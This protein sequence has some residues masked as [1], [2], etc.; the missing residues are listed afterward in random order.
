M[1]AKRKFCFIA[2]TNKMCLEKFNLLVL[3]KVAEF[4]RGN[5]EKDVENM[6]LLKGYGLTVLRIS[7]NEVNSNLQDGCEVT[8]TVCKNFLSQ[9]YGC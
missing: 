2:M 9:A 6:S 3:C 8:N 5:M 7:N 4:S 1:P